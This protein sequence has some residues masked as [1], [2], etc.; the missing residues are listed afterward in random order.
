MQQQLGLRKRLAF[1]E[2]FQPSGPQH[3][4]GTKHSVVQQGARLFRRQRYRRA[5]VRPRRLHTHPHAI[6]DRRRE[7]NLLRTER[8]SLLHESLNAKKHF[9]FGERVT[10]TLSV[11]YFNAFNRTRFQSPDGNVNAWHVRPGYVARLA[12]TQ[13]TGPSQCDEWNS[14][15][16]LSLASQLQ[17]CMSPDLAGLPQGQSGNFLYGHHRDEFLGIETWRSLDQL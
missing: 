1:P 13:S 3:L 14:D 7:E 6:C 11:D 16:T 10:A 15:P 17:Y 9:Y 8:P 5:D 2:W 12:N 4:C